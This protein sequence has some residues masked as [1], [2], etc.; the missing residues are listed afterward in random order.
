MA[1]DNKFGTFGGVFTP[2]ILTILGVIMYLRL[3]W[4]VGNSGFWAAI[5]IIVVAHIVS[6]ATGASVASIATDKTVGAGGPYYI[7]SR[8]LGL[9]IGGTIGVGLFVGLSFSI[10]LYVIGFSESFLTYWGWEATPTNIRICGTITVVLL[11]VVTLI[12][13]ALAIKTQYLI[14]AMIA[15]S[16]V[17]IFG[18]SP[19]E[20]A[21]E[22]NMGP[23]EGGA[24]M[25]VLFGIFFPA[26]TGFTAGVNMSG[27]LRDPKKSLPVGT[28]AAIAVGFIVYVALAAFLAFRV[29]RQTLVD[30]P[31]VLLNIAAVPALVVAG[32][33]GATISS[34]LGSILGAPRILQALSVD[35]IMPRFFARGEG[36]TNE[37]RRALL[38]AFA[39]GEAGILIAELD[40][41]ARIVSMVFLTMYGVVNLS[42]AVE[43]WVSP[44]FRPEFR[45]P[46]VFSIIGA[47][48]CALLMIQLDLVAMLGATA[49][50]VG[51]FVWLQR[52]QLRLDSGD[53]WEGIWSSIVRTGLHRLSQ[54]ASQQRNWRPNILYF[55]P[56]GSELRGPTLELSSALISGR[57][58]ITDFEVIP[59]KEG[60][61]DGPRHSGVRPLEAEP[62]EDLPLGI[63][64]RP[65]PSADIHR[66]VTGVCKYHGFSGLSPNTVLL[67]WLT[68]NDDG[69][70]FADL[71]Q[72]LSR[73][74]LNVLV[75]ARDPKR[76]LGNK[77]SIDVWWR[78]TAGNLPLSLSLL[79]FITISRDWRDVDIRFLV[80]TEDAS[81]VDV[82]QTTARRFLHE[83]RIE[84]QVRVINNSLGVKSYEDWIRESRRRRTSSSSGSRTAKR[85]ST[86]STSRARTS[87]SKTSAA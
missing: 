26:V 33:W 54:E 5:G 27:D 80:V 59:K 64:R 83:N 71:L 44:D 48:T 21:A 7:I 56:R 63:F 20:V 23:M 35:R 85:P 76:D 60:G 57:G 37:P 38:L 68:F 61:K 73:L 13:T 65:I 8:S 74:D 22:P 55:S 12:S 28:I 70:R 45:V 10:S 6:G 11:T 75:Y 47:L 52:R 25:A 17:S 62:D 3:P 49:A 40:A 36:P 82:L 30:D 32:I 24:S 79:R 72:R 58:I 2:S 43:S 1:K 46:R 67:D 19:S 53:A 66:T 87:C 42:A 78:A 86:P 18:G 41:I 77:H 51:L 84:A 69:E 9:P 81:N 15:L 14:L 31:E 50:M 34:A 39:L 16:L 29:P 4:V